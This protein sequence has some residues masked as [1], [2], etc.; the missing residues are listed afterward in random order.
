[1]QRTKH[2]LA[3]LG[4]C[5]RHN[6][7]L[8]RLAHLISCPK[9]LWNRGD[10]LRF[11]PRSGGW[12]LLDGGCAGCGVGF[13]G[14]W[15]DWG[16]FGRFVVASDFMPEKYRKLLQGCFGEIRD[17]FMSWCVGCDLI[18]MMG[19]Y[20]SLLKLRVLLWRKKKAC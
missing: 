1:M 4:I 2:P 6:I 16:A 13:Q 15:G 5:P 8:P 12:P 20:G 18:Y 10:L 9:T 19:C 7:R 17:C 11:L 14:D 3:T